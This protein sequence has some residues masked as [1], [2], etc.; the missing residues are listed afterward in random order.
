MSLCRSAETSDISASLFLSSVTSVVGGSESVC[1]VSLEDL[2]VN[3]IGSAGGAS[4]GEEGRSGASLE[5]I[6]LGEG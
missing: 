4:E 1:R 3:V 2:T 5:D 6:F